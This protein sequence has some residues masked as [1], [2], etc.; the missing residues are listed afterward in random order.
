MKKTH[1][2]C[3][4]ST[5][6]SSKVELDE[7]CRQLINGTLPNSECRSRR[8]S[9]SRCSLKSNVRYSLDEADALTATKKCSRCL[10]I[11]ELY[12]FSKNLAQAL[13]VD[14]QCKECVSERRTAAYKTKKFATRKK[15]SSSPRVLSID[16]FVISIKYHA[17]EESE[18]SQIYG[19][20]IDA[21]LEA[22]RCEA[23]G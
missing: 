8:K 22:S 9:Q 17:V 4:K 20:L 21:L 3:L 16:N 15:R 23:A 1:E 6:H 5:V 7:P 12:H 13:G 18:L 11:K 14:N 2:N 10:N 19:S